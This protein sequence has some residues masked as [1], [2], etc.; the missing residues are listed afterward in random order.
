M[1]PRPIPPRPG[2]RAPWRCRCGRLAGLALAVAA[3]LLAA[4]CTPGAADK[5]VPGPV[6]AIQ[7]LIEDD[8][9]AIHGPVPAGRVVFQIRNLGQRPH[10]LTLFPMPEDAGPI[11]QEVTDEKQRPVRLLA[12]VSNLQPGNTGTFAADLAAGQRYG[13]IDYSRAPD[14]TQHMALGVAGEFRT[15]QRTRQQGHSPAPSPS[16]PPGS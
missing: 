8:D 7:V 15:Q 12:R 9:L 6:P 2:G 5:P 14:G 16:P 1:N 4:G 10:R 3:A 11:E 13:L